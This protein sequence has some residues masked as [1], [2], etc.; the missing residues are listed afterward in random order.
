[1]RKALFLAAALAALIPAAAQASPCLQE[2][3]IWNWHALSDKTLIVENE[4]HQKFRL[5]LIG[6]CQNLRF[7]QNLGFRSVGGT[8]MSCLGPGDMVT[9][10]DFATGPQHCAI[11]HIEPYT[12]DMEAADRAAAAAQGQKY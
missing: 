4:V 10:H 8:G 9:S 12:H 1:M 11:T 6:T 2:N 7:Y 5:S 3:Q